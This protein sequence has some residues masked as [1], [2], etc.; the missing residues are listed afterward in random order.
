MAKATPLYHKAFIAALGGC[1][2]T[3]IEMT[4]AGPDASMSNAVI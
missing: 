1:C 4:V 3:R 2:M